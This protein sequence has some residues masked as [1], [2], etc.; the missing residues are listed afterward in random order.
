MSKNAYH[1]FLEQVPMFRGLDRR[2]LD[3]ITRV[4][5]DLDLEAGK[6]IM[7]EGTVAHEMVIVVDGVLEVLR[8]GEH[9]ADI[10][11]GGFA[12][13][14]GLLTHAK[15][16]STVRAKSDVSLLHIDGRAFSTLLNEV[17]QIAVKML[18]V[19]AARAG[20]DEHHPS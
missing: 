6:V 12:G 2:D 10:G 15:R 11:P 13:E 5:T 19:V 7:R 18:S 8:D 9:V 17:P 4:V 1:S 16:N 3:T 20:G 14:I